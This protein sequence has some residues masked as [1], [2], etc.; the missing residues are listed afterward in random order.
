M[1]DGLWWIDVQREREKDLLLPEKSPI[2]G[3]GVGGG[4]DHVDHVDL[5]ITLACAVPPAM[6]VRVG[7]CHREFSRRLKMLEAIAPWVTVVSSSLVG[8]TNKSCYYA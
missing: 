5:W 1:L 6:F 8:K 3:V 7:S 4:G 2:P